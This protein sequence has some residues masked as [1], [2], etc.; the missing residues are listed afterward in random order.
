M[1]IYIH[2]GRSK[3]KDCDCGGNVR[4]ADIA[5]IVSQ[6]KRLELDN[7]AFDALIQRLRGDGSIKQQDWQQIASSY[8]GFSLAAS[9]PKAKSI[10]RIVNT[11]ALNA[12]QNARMPT[13]A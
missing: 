6:I 11:Q 8:I 10:Q 1:Q 3:A 2:R 4:D 5:G 12:R 9:T 7:S 13:Q